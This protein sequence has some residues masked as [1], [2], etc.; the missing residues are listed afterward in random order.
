MW[1][2]QDGDR[3]WHKIEWKGVRTS[4]PLETT[5]ETSCGVEMETENEVE[6]LPEGASVC[7]ACLRD[8]NAKGR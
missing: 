4:E 2:T 1:W 5:L 3:V 7:D 8:E 6:T